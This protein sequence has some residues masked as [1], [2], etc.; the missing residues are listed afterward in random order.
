MSTDTSRRVAR[1]VFTV[2]LVLLAVGCGGQTTSSDP[3]K[4]GAT[5]A[6]TTAGPGPLTADERVWLEAIPKVH[7][8]IDKTLEATPNLTPSAMRKLANTLRS[9][10]RELLAAGPLSERLEPVYALVKKACREYDKGAACFATAARLGIT[11]AGSAEDRKQTKAIECGL[12][13]QEK[14]FSPFD[15]AET[16]SLG[17]QSAAG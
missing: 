4:P 9:C 16:L 15:S 2:T 14:A 3:S 7:K 12:A 10:T 6:P 1:L 5:P 17:I 8:Q 13:A 11:L